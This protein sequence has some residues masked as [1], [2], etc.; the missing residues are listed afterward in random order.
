MTVQSQLQ[1]TQE[2]FNAWLTSS[3][4]GEWS[5]THL[6]DAQKESLIWVFISM[7]LAFAF[8]KGIPL[9]WGGTWHYV[10]EIKGGSYVKVPSGDAGGTEKEVERALFLK[11][12]PVLAPIKYQTVLFHEVSQS[13][14]DRRKWLMVNRLVML[15]L[16][17]LGM[18][19]VRGKRDCELTEC[20][21]K[22]RPICI[23]IDCE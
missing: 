9:P 2:S 17:G 11:W 1:S 21:S 4:T 3:N 20:N 23:M 6:R 7:T 19:L 5:L 18:L 8:W 10:Y 16:G 12:V 13:E 14:R 15:L 22:G